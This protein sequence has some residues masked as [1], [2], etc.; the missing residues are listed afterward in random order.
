MTPNVHYDAYGAAD[1]GNSTDMRG[2]S[3]I[4]GRLG[5]DINLASVTDGT[6]NVIMVG[7]IL[8]DCNDHQS[9]WWDYNGMGNAHAST[10]VPLND[11]TTCPNS[12]RIT[13]PSCT[14]PNNWNYSWGFRSRHPG[15]A[16]FVFVDGSVKNLPQTIDYRTYQ[17]LGGRADGEPVGNF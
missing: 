15:G 11:H 16:Q 14:N 7:E 3:G 12:K 13:N 1:H 4:F 8:P 10:S 17:R 9:G 2:I 6:S 5:P